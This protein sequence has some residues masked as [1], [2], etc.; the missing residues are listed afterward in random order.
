MSCP[1]YTGELARLTNVSSDT[2]R[3]YERRRLLPAAPRSE[4][5]YRLFSEDAVK[6]VRLIRA[7]LALGFSVTELAEIFR[8]RNSGGAPCQK[9]RNLAA[10]KLT[11]LEERLRDLQAWKRELRRTLFQWDRLL[12]RTPKGKPAK[13]LESLAAKHRKGARRAF[14]T[15]LVRGNPKEEKKA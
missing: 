3:Y 4:A 2:L 8:E 1:L 9:V 5:G 13:L 6:R 7:A 15:V 12:S 10:Q 14:V 11:T